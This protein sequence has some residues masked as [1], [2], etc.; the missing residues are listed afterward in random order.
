MP[1]TISLGQL[2]KVDIREVWSN[3][4]HD[5]TPWLALEENIKLL[6]DTIGLEL[7]LEAQEKNVG[8]FRADIL[9]KDTATGNWVL[10]EN[11]LERTDHG[12]LGQLITYAAGLKA[13]TIIWI[14]SRFTD[15]HRAAV[16]WLNEITAGDFNFFGLEV[17]VWRIGESAAAPKF[18][19]A[20]A[21]NNWT[22]TVSQVKAAVEQGELTDTRQL[23]LEFWTG[24]REL[25]LERNSIIKPTKPLAQTWIA[26]STGK[27]GYSLT[28]VAATQDTEASSPDSHQIRAEFVILDDYDKATFALMET[29]KGT[30]EAEF[31]GPLVWAE[32]LGKKQSKIYVKRSANLDDRTQW[33]AYHDWLLQH[34]EKLHSVFAKRVKQMVVRPANEAV[35]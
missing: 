27:T 30:I 12:H 24:L 13:V 22:Q 3:E 28:A 18:N 1:I 32:T 17:E 33:P 21:P 7:E 2:A 6:G 35:V 19:L 34:L 23:Q 5:F 8:P 4:A 10:I 11:Q 26:F 16:D 15:E 14:S 31:G 20:C 9:C 29:S 25:M